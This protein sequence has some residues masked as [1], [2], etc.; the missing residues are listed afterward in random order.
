MRSLDESDSEYDSG[1]DSADGLSRD[2][3]ALTLNGSLSAD[4]GNGVASAACRSQ[5]RPVLTLSGLAP[6]LFTLLLRYCY[7][8]PRA[9]DDIVL[10]ATEVAIPVPQTLQ[11]S[12]S[13]GARM[14][15][16]GLAA[17]ASASASP[18]APASAWSRPEHRAAHEQDSHHRARRNQQQE[19]EDEL[20]LQEQ[21]VCVCSGLDLVELMLGAG[22]LLDSPEPGV[23]FF[24]F[25]NSE[26]PLPPFIWLVVLLNI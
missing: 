3:H 22:W 2:L 8:G 10:R 18:R 5:Q 17:P 24:V 19:E 16:N 4:D 6:P 9:L 1:A 11:R 20:E 12:G 23:F 7:E 13:R 25:V 14:R 15:Q 26:S 21:G